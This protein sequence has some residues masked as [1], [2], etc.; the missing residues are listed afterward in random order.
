MHLY[1]IIF[2][3]SLSIPMT[4]TRLPILLR[5]MKMYVVAYPR[6]IFQV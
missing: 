4:S 1:E 5:T 2:Y 3:A 6:F